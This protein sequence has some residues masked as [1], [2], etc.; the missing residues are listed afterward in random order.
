MMQDLQQEVYIGHYKSTILKT[1][2]MS[3]SLRT[4]VPVMVIQHFNVKLGD[5]L[6]WI[7]KTTQNGETI[8][9]VKP[10]KN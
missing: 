7:L 4:T 2:N 3:N 9:I 8:A 1:S 5:K 10:V 6:E